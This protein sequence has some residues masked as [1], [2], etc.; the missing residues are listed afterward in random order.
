MIDLFGLV[1]LRPWWLA[2][3]PALAAIILFAR[4]RAKR[5]SR[6]EA[7]IDPPLFAAL[8]RLGRVVPGEAGRRLGAGALAS[9]VAAIVLLA[10]TGPA[11]E[12]RDAATYRNLDAVVL[13]VDLGPRATTADRLPAMITA[14]RQVAEAAGARPIA[15]V[16]YA[17]DAYVASTFT[18]DANALGTTIAVLDGETVPDTGDRPTRALDLARRLVLEAGIVTADIVLVGPDRPATGALADAARRIAADGHRLSALVTG[19]APQGEAAG[20]AT[21]ARLGGGTTAIAA[22]P[23]PLAESLADS[24]ATRLTE[25]GLAALVWR[26]DGRFLIAA[27]LIPA[28]LLFRRRD[29]RRA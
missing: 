22:D 18:T 2:A 28:L 12:A 26:D 13:V 11:H 7:A 14:T 5:S 17:G 23:M 9:I 24:R 21:L 6:W 20:L 4:A 16:V 15:L 19:P 1:L 3:L 10:L 27:A 8:E 25:S 29:G